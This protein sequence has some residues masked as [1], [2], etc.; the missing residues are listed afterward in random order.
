MDEKLAVAN[1]AD[2]LAALM[3]YKNILERC[4]IS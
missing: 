4:F 1:Q 2:H 3:C